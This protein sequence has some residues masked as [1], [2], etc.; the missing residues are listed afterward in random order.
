MTKQLS[1]IV[2][3]ICTIGALSFNVLA[4]DQGGPHRGIDKRDDMHRVM[5]KLD[6][7]DQQKQQVKD[8]QSA[9]KEQ[10]QTLMAKQ[11]DKKASRDEFT[12]LIQAEEFDENA[13]MLLQQK[14]SEQQAQASLISAKSMHQ[15]YQLLTAEQKQQLTELKQQHMEKRQLKKEKMKQKKQ[16]K[17]NQ[18][19]KSEG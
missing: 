8:I 16:K 12:A 4:K 2:L 13:F 10:M 19:D 7:T 14:K 5:S 9:K 3:L 1:K 6:L 18:K 15:M 17:N 11:G